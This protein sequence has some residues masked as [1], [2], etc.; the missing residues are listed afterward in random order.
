MLAVVAAPVKRCG[1]AAVTAA[2]SHRRSA[3]SAS[4]DAALASIADAVRIVPP[5]AATVPSAAVPRALTVAAARGRRR[6]AGRI[7]TGVRGVRFAGGTDQGVGWTCIQVYIQAALRRRSGGEQRRSQPLNHLQHVK[8]DGV[9]EFT[10][11]DSAPTA[12]ALGSPA[13]LSLDVVILHSSATFFS[14]IP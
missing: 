13:L 10:R 11:T 12:S 6:R 14:M 9:E 7:V 8:W 2:H 4:I 5:V 1:S 3:E